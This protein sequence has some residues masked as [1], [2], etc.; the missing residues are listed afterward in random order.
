[1]LRYAAGVLT[2]SLVFPAYNQQDTGDTLTGTLT[3]FTA[4]QTFA[5]TI[6]PSAAQMR[7]GAL[8][9]AMSAFGVSWAAYAAPAYAIDSGAGVALVSGAP[10]ITDQSFTA[11]YGN[12][13]AP[14]N[15]PALFQYVTSESR[16]YTVGGVPITLSAGLFTVTDATTGQDLDLPVGLP[17]LLSVDQTPLNSDGT[18]LALPAGKPVDVSFIA[19]QQ[20]NTA[21]ELMM[22]DIV[23]TGTEVTRTPVFDYVALAPDFLVPPELFV[24][25]HTYVIRAAC[26]AGGEPGVTSGDLLARSLPMSVGY[27]DGAVFTVTN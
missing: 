14:Q 8:R 13:F 17:E 25:G 12:P 1:M 9:P 5:A 6:G 18:T 22:E 16:S 15:W 21:Y 26:I 24:A 3:A 19:D 20:G 11:S 10:A 7:Y 4:D 27:F 23:V 2:G